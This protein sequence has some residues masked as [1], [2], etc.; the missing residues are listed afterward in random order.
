MNVIYS[1]VVDTDNSSIGISFI[2][3]VTV[4]LLYLCVSACLCALC[5]SKYDDH[6]LGTK[7][8]DLWGN[9]MDIQH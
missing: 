8:M 3:V 6:R 1:I 2:L 5:E 7:S 4:C 9:T